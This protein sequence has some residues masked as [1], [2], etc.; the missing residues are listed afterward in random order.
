MTLRTDE[1]GNVT[2]SLRASAESFNILPQRNI[3]NNFATC[4]QPDHAPTTKITL[5]LTTQL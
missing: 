3:R 5:L 4:F 2:I 1:F